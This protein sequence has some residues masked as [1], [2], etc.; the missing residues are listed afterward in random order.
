MGFDIYYTPTA[1]ALAGVSK[2]GGTGQ[3]NLRMR[4]IL[5]QEQARRDAKKM[6]K[7]Q[8]EAQQE[9]FQQSRQDKFTTMQMEQ[10]A[11]RQRDTQYQEF[12]MGRDEAKAA[13]QGDLV[14]LKY[15]AKQRADIEKINQ[16]IDY[17]NQN[18][19][20]S[21]QQKKNAIMELE[22]RRGS[23]MKLPT[24]RQD[25]PFPDGQ[26]IGQTWEI[27]GGGVATRDNKGNIRILVK[28]PTPEEYSKIYDSVFKALSADGD[29]PDA[30]TVEQAV[31]DRLSAYGKFMSNMSP[32]GKQPG[33]AGA[34]QQAPSATSDVGHQMDQQRGPNMPRAAAIQMSEQ[35]QQA[36]GVRR[37]KEMQPFV[38]EKL[39]SISSGLRDLRG[40]GKKG[41]EESR[42]L[43]QT[44]VALRKL[45]DELGEIISNKAEG[46]SVEQALAKF[47]AASQG[48][49]YKPAIKDAP[50]QPQAPMQ[51]A[52]QARQQEPPQAAKEVSGTIKEVEAKIKAGNKVIAESKKIKEGETSK[53]RASQQTVRDALV[54]KRINETYLAALKAGKSKTEAMGA[55][56][57]AAFSTAML[58]QVSPE[59]KAKLEKIRQKYGIVSKGK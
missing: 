30:A 31:M 7:A 23:I 2:Q 46:G 57:E 1:A 17:I 16:D 51:A 49:E 37:A 27:G 47:E 36:A 32:A 3:Y 48:K 6:Q 12:L 55:A 8:L 33:A 24:P 58:G 21:P 26:D 20:M 34:A 39:K 10:D 41:A 45:K 50:T 22:R 18:P 53:V 4:E 15:S 35:E 9:Q 19:S 14:N 38:E 56:I 54:D 43:S 42:Q 44:K 52:P 28:P 59:M 13:Q 40:T 25:S 5:S 29:I 11:Q